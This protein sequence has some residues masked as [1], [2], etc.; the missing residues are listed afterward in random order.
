VLGDEVILDQLDHAEMYHRL[1]SRYAAAFEYLRATDFAA[2]ED[3]RHDVRGD[4]IFAIVASY[5]TKPHENGLWEAHRRYV[6]IHCMIKG[7]ERV[8][9]SPISAM[10][11]DVPYDAQKDAELFTGEGQ[12]IVIAPGDFALLMPQDVH[13]PGLVLA[14]PMQVRKVVMKVLV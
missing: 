13:M 8:G 3:G 9:V 10:H 12:F 11:V 5:Q 7:A 1:G 4:E 2:L 6:D 14:E